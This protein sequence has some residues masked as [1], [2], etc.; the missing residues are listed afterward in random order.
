VTTAFAEE[1]LLR[2]PSGRC[3]WLGTAVAG[4][5]IRHGRP[6]RS[7]GEPLIV[8]DAGEDEGCRSGA[9]IGLSW[10]GALEHDE[11]RR[12]LLG[13]VAAGPG[14]RFTGG[15]VPFAAVREARLD[16]LGDLIAKHTDTERLAA[17]IENGA[18][19]DLPVLESGVRACCAS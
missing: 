7:G 17:L 19:A 13:R 2:R 6:E 3:E 1:K 9:V 16:A 4:Y 12:A 8:T 14:R 5:E 18:P 11:F 10:H 15:D